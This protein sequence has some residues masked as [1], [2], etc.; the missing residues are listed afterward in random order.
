MTVGTGIASV[1]TGR[2]GVCALS[3]GS[4]CGFDKVLAKGLA[5]S[6]SMAS[7]A[8]RYGV[9]V[10]KTGSVGWIGRSIGIE[11]S[12]VLTAFVCKLVTGSL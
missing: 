8:C 6:F 1:S 5:L 9:C 4:V 7:S 3:A 12:L 2:R 11:I 10:V